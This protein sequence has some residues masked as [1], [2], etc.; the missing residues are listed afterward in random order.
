MLNSG[1]L[2]SSY[3]RDSRFSR[4]F[5]LDEFGMDGKIDRVVVYYFS[6]PLQSHYGGVYTKGNRCYT[7][8]GGTI[9]SREEYFPNRPV[10]LLS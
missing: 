6:Q 10:Q 4:R 5:P 2:S 3:Y 8:L 1:E 7:R 9:Y